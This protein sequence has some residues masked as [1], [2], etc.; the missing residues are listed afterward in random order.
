MIL[1]LLLITIV[2]SNIIV[3][4]LNKKNTLSKSVMI[5]NLSYVIFIFAIY[6]L[7]QD[8]VKA[9]NIDFDA[10]TF[11]VFGNWIVNILVPIS[12]MCWIY[13]FL[14][15]LHTFTKNKKHINKQGFKENNLKSK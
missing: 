14:I 13:P 7:I 11:K 2:F 8:W 10:S 3:V 1:I 5:H 4:Y 9:E 6:L 12:I 15:Y